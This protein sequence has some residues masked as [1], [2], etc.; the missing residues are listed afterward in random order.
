MACKEESGVSDSTNRGTVFQCI[1]SYC[2]LYFLKVYQALC[3]KSNGGKR[4][5]HSK[6]VLDELNRAQEILPVYRTDWHL[7]FLQCP[8]T[9]IL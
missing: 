6:E 3:C 4:P 1:P 9:V 7:V 8:D 2:K 5:V